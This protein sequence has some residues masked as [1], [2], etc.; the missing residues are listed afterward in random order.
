MLWLRCEFIV[1]RCLVLCAW[2]PEENLIVIQSWN[3]F[4]WANICLFNLYF[5]HI[6]ITAKIEMNLSTPIL[7]AFAFTSIEIFQTS[8]KVQGMVFF[9]RPLCPWANIGNKTL[10]NWSPLQT[11]SHPQPPSSLHR[12]GL[13]PK[14]RFYHSL[15]CLLA[16]TTYG[17]NP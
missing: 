14:C 4:L 16:F 2:D 5:T 15:A 12:R 7:C 6:V 10:E 13:Y 11:A 3:R 17:M 1:A 9:Q 8:W